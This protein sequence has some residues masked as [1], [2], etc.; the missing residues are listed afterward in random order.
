[1]P[2]SSSAAAPASSNAFVLLWPQPIDGGHALFNPTNSFLLQPSFAATATANFATSIVS[3]SYT[4]H[5]ISLRLTNTNYLY[6]QMQMNSYLLGQGVFDFVDGSNS[7]PSPHVLNA[8]G[9][10]LQVNQFFLRCK[11]TRPTHSKC[12]AFLLSMEVLHLIVDCQTSSFVW[13]TLEQALASTCN[14]RIMQLHGSLQDLRQG[15]KSVTQCM[16]KAKVLF[17]EL[18]TGGQPVSLKDFNLYMFRGLRGEFKDLV[19]SVVTKAKPLLYADLHSH[20]LTH[21]FLHKTSLSSMGYAVI[22][23]PL[24]S[25]PNTPLIVFFFLLPVSWKFW[26]QQRSFP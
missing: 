16:Q 15:D 8:D 1:V 23:T 12:S 24:L 3:L 21:K 10:S 26:P 19:T 17:D 11:T 18:A 22:N 13:R 6:C 7:C 4:N 5:V 25:T 14:S 9:T 20:L 2:A